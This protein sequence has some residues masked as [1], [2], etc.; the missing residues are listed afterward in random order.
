MKYPGNYH[1]YLVRLKKFVKVSEC[2]GFCV[3]TENAAV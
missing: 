2:T 1:L 3:D